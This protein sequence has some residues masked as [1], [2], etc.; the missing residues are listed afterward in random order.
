VLRACDFNGRR[1]DVRENV[2]LLDVN[3]LSPGNLEI[4][5]KLAWV[6]FTEPV[7]DSIER[8]AT[9]ARLYERAFGN[10]DLAIL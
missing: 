1:L 10:R 3:V 7:L 8:K 5:S 9:I 6:D 4:C 2:A